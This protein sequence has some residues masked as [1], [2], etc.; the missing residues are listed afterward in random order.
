[1]ANNIP[2]VMAQAVDRLVKKEI[3]QAPYDKTY[4]GIIQSR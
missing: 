4:S 1:M 2:E 3:S